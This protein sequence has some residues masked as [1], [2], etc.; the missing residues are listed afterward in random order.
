MASRAPVLDANILI[1]AVLGNRVRDILEK[2]ANSVSF[3][4]PEYAY[5]E[6]EGHLAALITKRGGD[7]AKGLIMLRAVVALVDLVTMDLYGDY[8]VEARKRLG[9]RDPEGWPILAS[10]LLLAVQSGP[11]IPTSSDAA[12]PLGLPIESRFS[13]ATSGHWSRAQIT[14]VGLAFTAPHYRFCLSGVDHS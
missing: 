11:R 2:Y 8:E 6:A 14:R 5:G 1:R 13:W 4:V 12:L 10:A 9:T 7:P 3:F